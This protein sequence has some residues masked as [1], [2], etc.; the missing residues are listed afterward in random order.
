MSRRPIPSPWALP[1]RRRSS[2]GRSC[3]ASAARRPT[4]N[5][6]RARPRSGEDE[7]V[8][9]LCAVPSRS[10]SSSSAIATLL[11]VEHAGGRDE[12]PQRGQS[13]RRGPCRARRPNLWPTR[14]TLA[15]PV[16]GARSSASSISLA[17]GGSVAD[18]GLA[19][20]PPRSPRPATGTGS[21]SSR[22]PT[23][24]LRRR[25]ENPRARNP[26][27]EQSA[28][29]SSASRSARSA[30]SGSTSNDRGR[31]PILEAL[32]VP[33]RRV[34]DDARLVWPGSRRTDLR[35]RAVRAARVGER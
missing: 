19:R 17:I 30:S 21:R 26:R 7:L 12:P 25:R 8:A 13:D 2:R 6:R 9:A 11:R 18:A 33:F 3:P 34:A 28:Q 35:H 10:S 16:P 27:A 23:G 32:G 1:A 29:H 24:S 31:V 22:A 14:F 15:R 5:S 20:A 4:R